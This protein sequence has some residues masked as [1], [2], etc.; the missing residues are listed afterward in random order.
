MIS[1]SEPI[2]GIDPANILTSD[3]W[4]P[5]LGGNT[6]VFRHP[7]CVNEEG[8]PWHTVLASQAPLGGRGTQGG[9]S[10]YREVD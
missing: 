10:I 7:G 4:T 1:L 6:I 5:E 2:E 8:Q 9:G 3:V